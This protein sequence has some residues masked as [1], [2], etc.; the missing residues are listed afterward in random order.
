MPLADAHVAERRPSA[1]WLFRLSQAK[2]IINKIKSQLNSNQRVSLH[3]WQIIKTKSISTSLMVPVLAISNRRRGKPQVMAISVS[4]VSSRTSSRASSR[5]G[6]RASFGST[7]NWQQR[8]TSNEDAN[9]SSDLV[10]LAE[11]EAHRNWLKATLGREVDLSDAEPEAP[12]LQ[13]GVTSDA[14]AMLEAQDEMNE[15]ADRQ[16]V[17]ALARHEAWVDSQIT[18]NSSE[19]EEAKREVW[20]QEQ[21]ALEVHIAP[22]HD[23]WLHQ[24]HMPADQMDGGAVALQRVRKTKMLAF[25]T[26]IAAAIYCQSL[27]RGHCAR[28]KDSERQQRASADGASNWSAW[29]GAA[30]SFRSASRDSPPAVTRL[31]A[32]PTLPEGASSERSEGEGATA[33][34]GSSPPPLPGGPAF[35]R[36]TAPPMLPPSDSFSGD[37]ECSESGNSRPSLLLGPPSSTPPSTL[38]LTRS[39]SMP[40]KMPPPK[41]SHV[42]TTRC[43]LGGNSAAAAPPRPAQAPS[44]ALPPTTLALT[45]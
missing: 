29:T 25:N 17:N 27:W 39:P 31:T 15:R 26:S 11:S 18:R 8:N 34:P 1:A 24:H 36:V 45:R 20:R 14:K 13:R 5:R 23:E 19:V 16:R 43:R 41:A 38:T 44:D 22:S 42:E 32:P 28:Q 30:D 10:H 33:A 12:K 6:S 37:G 9:S 4:G 21:H 2:F 7:V 35:T 3:P 40:P